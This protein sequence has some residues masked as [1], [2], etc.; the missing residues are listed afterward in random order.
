[1]P[2]AVD[3]P[4]PTPRERANELWGRLLDLGAPES[5]SA[6]TFAERLAAMPSELVDGIAED[7]L[8][9]LINTVWLSGWQPAEVR[10]HA[11][12]RLKAGP[13]RLVEIAVLA[14]HA[15]RAGQGLD[16]RWAAQLADFG[17]RD[18]TARSG[19]LADWRR[20]EALEPAASYL[21]LA[22][23]RDELTRLPP[24]DV[25]IP[26]PGAPASAVTVGAPLRS[27]FGHPA[28]ER[29]RKLLA[30]AEATEFEGEAAALTAKA[31]EM[32]T[33][34]AI[35]EAMVAAPSTESGPRMVRLP[36]DP[37]YADAKAMLVS[38]VASANRGRAILLT[39][40]DLCAVIGHADELA[41]IEL[42]YT[43][44]LVQAQNALREAG[45]GSAGGRAR[46]PTFRA[47]F[48]VAY[49]H[50]IG[51]RLTLTNDEVVGAAGTDA[52]P[53]LRRRA[54]AVEEFVDAHYGD[55]TSVG[56][57]RGAYDPEGHHHGRRAADR[58]RLDSGELA[59]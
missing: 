32:M 28:L 29:I 51:E 15:D 50:R 48:L 41:A 42:L 37:P 7:L 6:R 3:V 40:L 20:R 19:W 2:T 16:P 26:P 24:L 39:G 38:V 33:R 57:V 22:A 43:S 10:R 59:S 46:N 55:R 56:S 13:A 27:G 47:S 4:R 35:D 30:K 34:H 9:G 58:A 44:L 21:S 14:D 53:V 54:D 1:M 36:V 49:A 45:R 11:R 23:A 31:Q 5:P 25:L 18:A 8:V 12:R 17:Q 52:L